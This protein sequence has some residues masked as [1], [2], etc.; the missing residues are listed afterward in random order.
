MSKP[1]LLD[2]FCCQGGAARGYADAGFEVVGVDIEPQPRYPF[3]F[4]QIDALALNRLFLARF[5]AIHASPPCQFATALRHA[6]NG[7]KHPN[8]IPQTR[9]LLKASGLPY[10]IEN[11]EQAV[12]HLLSPTLLCGTMFGLGVDGFELQRHRLFETSFPLSAPECDHSG[13]PVVGVYGGH[14][15]NRSS[16]HGGRGTR[17]IWEG[18]HRRAC[19]VSMGMDWATLDGMSE[20]IPPAYTRFIGAQLLQHL[21]SERRAA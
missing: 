3:E 16:K 19:S 9:A 13:G 6:P 8:L 15:R 21:Q 5:D 4:I 17:D 12:E 2:L 7:K 10:V 1:R 14:A 18:G 11:V 20:A